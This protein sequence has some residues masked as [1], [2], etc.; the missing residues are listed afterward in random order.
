M[1]R[2]AL[3]LVA[4]LAATAALLGT[5]GPA[6]AITG[7]QPDGDDHPNVGIVLSG[8]GSVR[9]HVQRLGRILRRGEGKRALLYEV[10]AEDTGE[11][12]TSLRRRR[13]DAYRD[14]GEPSPDDGA[15]A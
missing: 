6:G 1:R 3:A 11:E 13:H 14:H 4:A 2:P 15:L 8:S 5:V 7:G 10:V 12:F 9:E